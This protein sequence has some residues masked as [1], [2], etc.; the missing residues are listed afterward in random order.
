MNLLWE[1]SPRSVRDVID[2]LPKNPAYTTIATVMHNLQ[3]KQLVRSQKSGRAVSYFPEVSR[4]EHTA[5]MMR[6]ALETSGDP[7]ASILHFIDDMPPQE[8]AMLRQ[9]LNES[10][11]EDTL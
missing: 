6:Q 2:A 10:H 11:H 8:L 5:M 4:E 3:R 1:A 7:R 9:Y